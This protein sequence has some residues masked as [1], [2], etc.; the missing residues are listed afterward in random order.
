MQKRLT[1]YVM[2]HQSIYRWNVG[3]IENWISDDVTYEN[4]SNIAHTYV[5]DLNLDIFHLLICLY[6][7]YHEI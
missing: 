3:S 7:T 1:K 5:F 2:I 4:T 6:L